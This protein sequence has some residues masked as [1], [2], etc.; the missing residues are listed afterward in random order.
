MKPQNQDVLQN[1]TET[2][3]IDA[4]IAEPSDENNTKESV[5]IDNSDKN[6]VDKKES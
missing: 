6:V 3:E 5:N 1:H 4:T 2:P